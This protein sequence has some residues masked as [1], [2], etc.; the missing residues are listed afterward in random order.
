MHMYIV[1]ACGCV[2]ERERIHGQD[3]PGFSN[4][5]RF[6][7]YYSTM[8][9]VEVHKAKVTKCLKKKPFVLNSGIDCLWHKGMNK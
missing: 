4:V 6:K 9:F 5:F 7:V 3:R 8:Y 2:Y 1:C